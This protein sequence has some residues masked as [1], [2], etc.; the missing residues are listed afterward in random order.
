MPAAAASD[1]YS[2]VSSSSASSSSSTNCYNNLNSYSSSQTSSTFSPLRSATSSLHLS[3]L[4]NTDY[5]SMQ[6]LKLQQ[7]QQQY[8]TT[9]MRQ[10]PVARISPLIKNQQTDYHSKEQSWLSCEELET[11]EKRFT[12]L[13]HDIS[14]KNT[15]SHQQY[16]Q[17]AKSCDR[18]INDEPKPKPT[19]LSNS[20]KSLLD[21]SKDENRRARS[22]KSHKLTVLSDNDILKVELSYR[23]I[24]THVYAA[25][26]LCDLYITTAER[27][28][29]LEDWILFQHGL[30]VWLLNSGTNPKRQSCL[31]LVIAEYGS[32]FPIW[33]D[34]VDGHSDVKQAREQHITF[35]LSDKVTLAVLRF[36]NILASKEFFSYY[37][38]VRNDHRYKH[39][40]SNG[41]NR[42]SSCGS[43]L[44]SKRKSQRPVNKSS[45]SNPCQFQHI[46]R[47]Q[48][49]DCAHLTT[50]NQCLMSSDIYS[51]ELL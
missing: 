15:S 7:R 11:I 29:K 47:L 21:K 19:T 28:A 18:L 6:S 31:S 40:F 32:G 16:E 38:S 9:R 44:T 42:S 39:L 22:D 37:V 5:R 33:Q 23:S 30:P 36:N 2:A 46:T 43:I 1:R 50:L 4:I 14:N 24:G 12:D 41:H 26:S 45:I 13:L 48:V 25:R 27:L 34:N 8:Q 35:R 17:R 49:K 10:T 20:R 3:K 51:N